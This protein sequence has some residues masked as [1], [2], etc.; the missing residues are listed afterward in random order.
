MNKRIVRTAGLT[1][2]FLPILF[3][4]YLQFKEYASYKNC[5]HRDVNKVVKIN[6]HGIYKTVAYNIIGHP[7]YYFGGSKRT[8]NNWLED[9]GINLPANVFL[10]CIR[11]K[12]PTTFFCVLPITDLTKLKNFLSKNFSIKKI[13][14]QR[15][16][17]LG[18]SSDEK[19]AVAFS[20]SRIAI[21]YS[22][23]REETTSILTDLLLK[24]S[25]LSQ[26]SIL[27]EQLKKNNSHIYLRG[28]QTV[29]DINFAKG[30][31]D[32]TAEIK[33]NFIKPHLITQHRRFTAESSIKMWLG[34]DFTIA[35]EK[36]IWRINDF[37]IHTDSIIK[38]YKGYIDIEMKNQVI[39]DEK[40]TSYS[41]NDDFQK[42]EQVSIVKR[43]IPEITISI[44]SNANE[45]SSY[46]Q[47]QG[48]LNELGVNKKLFPL[49]TLNTYFKHNYLTVS[50][51][52][53]TILNHSLVK[54]SYFLFLEANLDKIRSKKQIP[55]LIPYISNFST[56]IL[57]G[58]QQE[59]NNIRLDGSIRFDNLKINALS[60][61]TFSIY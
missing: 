10:Y 56:F 6:I 17:S 46:L 3:V 49:Y 25:L 22:P 13:S 53:P 31:I 41:Y 24:K 42:T 8:K 36:S 18:I 2:I 7:S 35:P 23:E 43:K 61:I 29:A 11:T 1:I 44:K 33:T 39:Q 51:G 28:A 45:L 5:I 58:K 48:V 54:S 38:Y 12:S 9:S 20:N 40:V 26:S 55:L 47:K 34:A 57:K 50:T 16:F 37:V 27:I 60:Q 15:S 52:N 59:N 14:S 30:S 21:S 19:I 4:A 32:M